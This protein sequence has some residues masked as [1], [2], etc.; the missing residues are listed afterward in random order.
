MEEKELVQLAQEG[1]EEAFSVLVKKYEKKVFNLAYGLTQNR[2]AADDLAQEVFIKACFGLPQFHFKSEFGT[3]L[4]RIAVNQIN[5]YLRKKGRMK[6]ISLESVQ[7]KVVSQEDDI[8]QREKAQ[9][10]EQRRTLVH[11]ILQSLPPKY[12][13]ILALRDIQGCSYGEI[14]GILKVSPGTVDSRLHRARR[15]L[16]ERLELFLSQ[17]GG[18]NEM[19]SS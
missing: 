9:V 18:N 15:M 16:R 4:Y 13:L 8:L 3:W 1:S 14:S 10:D 11:K 2:E 19:P 6:E 5:D 12:S 17:R 7:E